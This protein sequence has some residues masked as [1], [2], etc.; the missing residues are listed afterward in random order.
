MGNVEQTIVVVLVTDDTIILEHIMVDPDVD[1]IVQSQAIAALARA[2]ELQIPDNDIA[3]APDAKA[4]ASEAF[5]RASVTNPDKVT[6]YSLPE[7]EPT[8]T[9]VV[10]PLTSMIPQP[11]SIPDTRM[12]PPLL[13]AELRAEHEVT[14]VPEPLPPPV[15]PAP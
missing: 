4:A 8:P 9:M 7:L 10:L 14:V 12:T 11:L 13:T 3:D 6:I 5:S 2:Q 15:V 1:G